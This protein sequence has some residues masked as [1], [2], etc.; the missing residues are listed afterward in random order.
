MSDATALRVEHLLNCARGRF[1]EAVEATIRRLAI[2][3]RQDLGRS[4]YLELSAAYIQTVVG[5]SYDT[6]RR[7]F[8]RVREVVGWF[9]L[10]AA[11]VRDMGVDLRAI[12]W[13]ER[14]GR[15]LV[16]DGDV[17]AGVYAAALDAGLIE[18]R[19]PDD[20]CQWEPVEPVKRGRTWM[21]RCP[22][23]TDLGPSMQLNLD[24]G[25]A[26]CHA[27]RT[28]HRYDPQGGRV[29]APRTPA[30]RGR[31]LPIGGIVT[32]RN[33]EGV[34]GSGPPP[35]EARLGEWRGAWLT[36]G[37]LQ[38]RHLLDCPFE[39]VVQDDQRAATQEPPVQDTGHTT[40]DLLLHLDRLRVGEWSETDRGWKPT[41]LTTGCVELVAVDVDDLDAV[42]PDSP[43]PAL[44]GEQ[45]GRWLEADGRFTGRGWLID[46]SLHG[47]Q[48]VAELETRRGPGWRHTAEALSLH[49]DLEV[50]VL[51]ALAAQGIVGGHVDPCARGSSRMV[52]RPG[53][54]W[55]PK[56]GCGWVVRLRWVRPES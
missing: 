42:W 22:F 19:A 14:H 52:R 7:A 3:R 31:Q 49:Q 26:Y 21:A 13:G 24:T 23:H 34:S 28:S 12:R 1:G 32:S 56:I 35:P 50:V 36:S 17:L 4:T 6:A 10:S 45:I 37:G 15:H 53:R 41:A 48:V 54:R 39:Q 51:E 16:V 9:E 25:V 5:C 29:S 11:T 27:C 33:Q 46:T 18:D 43:G 8:T 20:L 2:H 30:D 55:C 38:R 40:W 47:V 44:A